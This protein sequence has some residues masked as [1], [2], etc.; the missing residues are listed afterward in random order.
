M[1]PIEASAVLNE[2]REIARLAFASALGACLCL[3]CILAGIRT[4]N[5]R[6][7]EKKRQEHEAL[8]QRL[9]AEPNRAA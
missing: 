5:E 9:T 6:R 3:Y 8:M 4:Y 7:W 2:I 1:E